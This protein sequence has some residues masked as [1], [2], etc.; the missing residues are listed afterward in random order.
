MRFVL[1]QS[2]AHHRKIG[3]TALCLV[4]P[5]L[6]STPSVA[7]LL[8]RE[9]P[10]LTVGVYKQ[11]RPDYT[12]PGLY[13]G[14][15][16]FSSS[17]PPDLPGNGLNPLQP[18]A[19][20]PLYDPMIS[21]TTAYD[22]DIYARSRHQTEDMVNTTTESLNFETD[23]AP[24]LLTGGVYAAEQNFYVHPSENA[25]AY[26]GDLATR[27]EVTDK[28]F[29]EV[30]GTFSRQ[31][32]LRAG[33]EADS[34]LAFRPV[35][36]EPSGVASFTQSFDRVTVEVQYSY[37]KLAYQ[38]VIEESRNVTQQAVSSYLAY[39]VTDTMTMFLRPAVQ[40]ITYILNPDLTDSVNVG[41]TGGVRYELAGT[42]K[43][44]LLF[45]FQRQSFRNPAFGNV[46]QP[47]VNGYMLWNMTP[48]T[49]LEVTAAN[50]I[51]P[52][53]RFCGI[54]GAETCV[55]TPSQQVGSGPLKVTG[56]PNVY[57]ATSAGVTL[58][59][60]FWHDLLGELKFNF[61]RDEFR[62]IRP[63]LVQETYQ[64]VTNARYLVDRDAEIDLSYNYFS[65]TANFP[66][67]NFYNS[68]PFHESV[69][70]LTMK[71][72]L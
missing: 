53:L 1:F 69:L 20:L 61:E 6:A 39:R 51:N 36:N 22:D 71:A 43:F 34:T 31:P 65:R 24:N 11:D 4:I 70:T 63:N 30:S 27:I 50:A 3:A 49:S 72:G 5:L 56:G 60:E 19:W 29:L 2:R 42:L 7:Q 13:I 64:L 52:L 18:S 35:Y 28:G 10:Q 26:E 59:H 57:V 45:G 15:F 33:L 23:W 32:Q 25:D 40:V 68:G 66:N 48:V 37:D 55:V 54:S 44:D 17:L 8:P 12:P 16:H 67:V 58:Q 62:G 21:Q 46:Y 47:Q 9:L 38:N 41:V 14:D